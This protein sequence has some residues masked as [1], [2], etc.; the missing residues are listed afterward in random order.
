MSHLA[1][2]EAAEAVLEQPDED[3]LVEL[4]A[5]IARVPPEHKAE[6][7]IEWARSEFWHPLLMMC[8]GWQGDVA[9][10]AG[11]A[12][13]RALDK[14][15]P[16]RRWDLCDH[17]VGRSSIHRLLGMQG[18]ASACYACLPFRTWI[19]DDARSWIAAA[20]G[21]QPIYDLEAAQK[22]RHLDIRDVI[23]WDPR[24]NEAR[25]AGEATSFSGFV[26]PERL[27]TTLKVWG[28]AGAYFRAWATLRARQFG[29]L[30][31]AATGA[32][33]HPASELPDSGMPG[34]LLI[35]NAMRARW[36]SPDVGSVIAG[37]G[38]TPA[39]LQYAAIRAANL[40]NFEGG[41]RGRGD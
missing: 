20:I 19:D 31:S 13:K 10:A 37:P 9:R 32:W 39:E 17:S 29:I 15:T 40:P 3:A 22:W 14:D 41:T 4:M 30:R 7:L 1:V 34:A 18:N 28:D 6:T 21:I 38:L 11:R 25:L 23:L 35:G 8:V 26:M 16:G 5:E 24:T 36:P 33:N 2:I 27:D 12:L